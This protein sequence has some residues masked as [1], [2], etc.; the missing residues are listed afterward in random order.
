MF[1]HVSV[2]QSKLSKVSVCNMKIISLLNAKRLQKDLC[3]VLPHD[4]FTDNNE[5]EN[6]DSQEKLNE[7]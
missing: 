1:C 2:F 3:S 5:L 7:L 6:Q 4:V